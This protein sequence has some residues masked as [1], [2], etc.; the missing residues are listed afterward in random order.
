MKQYHTD[1]LINVSAEAVWQ[2]LNNF[3]AYASWN[4]LISHLE[5]DIQEGGIIKASIVPLKQTMRAQLMVYKPN[6][7][8][9]WEGKLLTSSLLCVRHY[10]QLKSISPTQT[11][12]LH[13]ETFTGIAAFFIPKSLLNKMKKVFIEHN[14]RLKSRLEQTSI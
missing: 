3:E 7:E 8:L 4:P 6:E 13:G 14:V 2:E 9:T 10:Y 1:I 11:H 12:L 5:G